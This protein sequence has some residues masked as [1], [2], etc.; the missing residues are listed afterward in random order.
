MLTL[1]LTLLLTLMWTLAGHNPAKLI[2]KSCTMCGAEAGNKCGVKLAGSHAKAVG[3]LEVGSDMRMP[4]MPA[5]ESG[6]P[7]IPRCHFWRR[8]RTSR[9]RMRGRLPAV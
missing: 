1:M 6:M 5:A 2:P 7:P 3:V 4:P 9:W 8:A